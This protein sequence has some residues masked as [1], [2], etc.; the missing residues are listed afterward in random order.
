MNSAGSADSAPR[1]RRRGWLLVLT[2]ALA[3]LLLYIGA[4]AAVILY[5][6]VAPPEPPLPLGAAQLSHSRAAH[7]IDQWRYSVSQSACEI[8]RFYTAVAQRCSVEPIW[9]FDS[10]ELAPAVGS[11]G[12]RVAACTADV[13]FSLF[14]MRWNV[15]IEGGYEPAAPTRLYVSREISWMGA[16]PPARDP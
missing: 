3:A 11:G 14:L 2:I 9:C 10:S 8:V 4:Q 6:I 15:V 1:A 12:Q 16:L 7:G 13:P 5:A